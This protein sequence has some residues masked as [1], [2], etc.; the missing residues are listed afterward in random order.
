MTL[1]AFTEIASGFQHS[2]LSVL[3]LL[4]HLQSDSPAGFLLPFLQLGRKYEPR[5][6]GW[7]LQRLGAHSPS[8][9]SF[10]S[11][12]W[13]WRQKQCA[14]CWHLEVLHIRSLALLCLSLLLV[15]KT[16]WFTEE[17]MSRKGYQIK[18]QKAQHFEVPWSIFLRS[19]NGWLNK[20]SVAGILQKKSRVVV[21][22]SI[23]WSVKTKLDFFTD[24]LGKLSV[25]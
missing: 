14:I 25:G 22:I 3:P 15:A 6:L 10:S 24:Q 4:C 11:S 21:S 1:A 2:G 8:C 13:V 23:H 7:A 20:L 17:C 18:S 16:E 19:C 9:C 5:L 12:L